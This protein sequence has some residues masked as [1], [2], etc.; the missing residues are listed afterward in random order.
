MSLVLAVICGILKEKI[1]SPISKL[2]SIKLAKDLVET[3]NDE[4][5]SLVQKSPLM[6]QMEKIALFQA[7]SDEVERGKKYF[8]IDG[9]TSNL[10]L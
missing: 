1:C 7:D 10:S 4:F 3:M 2:L 6:G 8:H 5:I 9:K